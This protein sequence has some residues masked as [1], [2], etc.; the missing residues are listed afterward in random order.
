MNLERFSLGIGDRF[1]RQGAAQLQAFHNAAARGLEL[2]PVWNKSNREHVI[3]G[4]RPQDTR[5]AADRAVKTA[6]WKGPY[7]VDADH[8]GLKTVEGFLGCSDFF[9]IDVADFLGKNDPDASE[10][11]I[12]SMAPFAGELRIPGLAPVTV[13]DE[14]LKTYGE[15]YALA[16][17]EAGKVY[18]RI[19]EARG[20]DFVAEVSVDEVTAPQTPLELFFLLGALANEGVKVQTIAPKFSGEFHKG[21]D[22]VGDPQAFAKEFEDDLLVVA[23]AVRTFDLPHNLKL[24]VHS[25]SDKFSLYRSIGAAVKRQGAGLHL[26]TAGTT[27]L[28]EIAGLAASGGEGLA[29]A[30]TIYEQAFERFDEMCAPYKAVVSIDR[31]RL[32]SPTDVNG[33]SADELAAAIRHEPTARYNPDLRQLLHVGYK[34][35]AELG[36]RYFDALDANARIVGEGV[37]ANLWERHIV[38]LYFS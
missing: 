1:G 3:V 28:E 33:W 22:Y 32:P 11:F 6:G 13:T 16:V 12:R 21:V 17:R 30:R 29:V 14:L 5:D 4:T 26:K 18:R 35:A 9:T 31:A 10:A 24:S 36:Q 2:V 7:H 19:A 38:P 34:V 15:R 8:I 25:G 23:H 37:T 27:W 20:T